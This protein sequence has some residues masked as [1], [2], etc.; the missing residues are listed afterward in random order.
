MPNVESRPDQS[1]RTVGYVNLLA[2]PAQIAKA[3]VK[4]YEMTLLDLKQ[5][6]ES[7]IYDPVTIIF[8]ENP[9]EE[10]KTFTIPYG[11]SNRGTKDNKENNQMRKLIVNPYLK[12]H[13]SSED[14]TNG[15][16]DL[17][18]LLGHLSADKSKTK[19]TLCL[20]PLSEKYLA[21]VLGN[22]RREY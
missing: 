7:L 21:G 1:S 13:V 17:R 18:E 6:R 10:M 16:A 2:S 8:I 22:S 5:T 3:K 19:S 14:D 12:K 9:K 20:L 4:L 11:F 15:G